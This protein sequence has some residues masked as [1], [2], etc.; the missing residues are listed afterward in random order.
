MIINLFGVAL[1]RERVSFEA[2]LDVDV[3]DDVPAGSTLK[4]NLSRLRLDAGSGN[5]DAGNLDQAGNLTNK[6]EIES[7]VNKFVN[8]LANLNSIKYLNSSQARWPQSRS[9]KLPFWGN[10]LVPNIHLVPNF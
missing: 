6:T 9:T 2:G 5:D 4:R 3:R 8:K 7:F 10:Y 1:S